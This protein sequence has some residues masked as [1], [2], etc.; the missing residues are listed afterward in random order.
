MAM[1]APVLRAHTQ[2]APYVEENPQVITG[3]TAGC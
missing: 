1:A 3:A 2:P